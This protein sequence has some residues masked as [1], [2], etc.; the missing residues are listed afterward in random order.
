MEKLLK[1]RPDRVESRL[2]GNEVVALDLGSS[3]YLAINPSGAVL[4]PHLETGST[5]EELIDALSAR[6]ALPRKTAETDVDTFVSQLASRG[7]LED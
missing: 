7:L 2:V 5:R 4:W 3:E 6:F 1:I